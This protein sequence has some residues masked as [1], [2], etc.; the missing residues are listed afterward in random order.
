MDRTLRGRS[1]ILILSTIAMMI[2]FMAWSVLSPIA[3][4]IQ[5]I[6]GLSATERSLLIAVPVILGSVFRIPMGILTDKF[7]GK[8]IYTMTML[9]LLIPLVGAGLSHS[10]Y[11]L[12]F[13]AFLIGM[14]GTTFAVG[15][16]YVSKWY[17][18]EKQGLVLGL[19][20]L[21]NLGTG[22]AGFILPTVEQALGLDWV[23]YTLAVALLIV[24]AIFWAGTKEY[25]VKGESKTLKESLSV[26]K[27]KETWVLSLFYFLTFGGFVAFGIYLPTL[28]QSVFGLSAADSGARAAGFVFLATFIRPVGGY[29]ADKLGAA[30][31]LTFLFAGILASAVLLSIMLNNFTMFTVGALSA[32]L[33]VGL[34]NGAVFKL[35]PKVAPGNVGAVTGIVGAAGGLG[36]FFPPIALGI[37]KDITGDYHLGFI[38]LAAFALFCLIINLLQFNG[39]ITKVHKD[40]KAV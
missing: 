37:V 5:K 2:S 9:F 25:P 26:I 12:M 28:L 20:A 24:T 1:R 6:Y 4:E 23:F 10:Y 40:Q 7:G 34:G 33:F 35:V 19:V 27:L 18:A 32:A 39:N 14:G 36:G 16:A 17:P 21:G 31:L 3:G 8:K 22:L 30:R 11:S 29:I 15:I 38:F 13:W